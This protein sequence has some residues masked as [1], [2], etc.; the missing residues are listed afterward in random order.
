[1]Q[2]YDFLIV[3]AGMFGATF[4][5]LAKDAGK[6]CLVIDKRSNIGGNCYTEEISGIHVH[7]YG[8]HIFHC[9]D[10]KIWRF[11]NRFAKFRQFRY[12]PIALHNGRAYS[13]PPNLLTVSLQP[14]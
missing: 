10:T 5:R 6:H 8:P 14:D 12:S 1:M 2:R 9:E 13:L 3:G 11:V 7:R 4:A